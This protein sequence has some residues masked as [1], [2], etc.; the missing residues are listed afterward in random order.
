MCYVLRQHMCMWGVSNTYCECSS[1]P[2]EAVAYIHAAVQQQSGESA[3]RACCR[4]QIATSQTALSMCTSGTYSVRP[5]VYS[6]MTLD[7]VRVRV[8]SEHTT[9][10]LLTTVQLPPFTCMQGKPVKSQ[11]GCS[12][13]KGACCIACPWGPKHDL[14]LVSLG[15]LQ[16]LPP[17]VTGLHMRCSESPTFR[18]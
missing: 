1:N 16:V 18:T 3:A 8:G 11:F 12:K 4:I 17:P 6:Q 13:V 5:A 10:P 2:V 9:W 14:R 15:N 7:M